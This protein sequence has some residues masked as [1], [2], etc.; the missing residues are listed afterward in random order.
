MILIL[1]CRA[2]DNKEGSNLLRNELIEI[3]NFPE[4]LKDLMIWIFV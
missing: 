4:I 2:W 3:G 1:L